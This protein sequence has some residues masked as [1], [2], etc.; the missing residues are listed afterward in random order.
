MLFTCGLPGIYVSDSFTM[1]YLSLFP[2]PL[3]YILVMPY[4][5]ISR[6]LS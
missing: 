4:N 6:T 2:L 3:T 1:L 5:M